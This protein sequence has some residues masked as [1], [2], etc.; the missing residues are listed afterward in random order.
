MSM[1]LPDRVARK[2]WRPYFVETGF[3]MGDG[4][5]LALLMGY[6]GIVSVELVPERAAMGR[7]RYEKEIQNGRVQIIEGRSEQVLP[8]LLPQLH[9]PTTFWLDAHDDSGG[10]QSC[11]YQEVEA[12][13]RHGIG[14]N[15]VMV[16]DMRLFGNP[17][18]W[19][20]GLSIGTLR[21]RAKELDPSIQFFYEDSKIAQDDILVM[22]GG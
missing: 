9:R 22:V 1:T 7:T 8:Q 3:C 13:L 21:G 17:S 11:V 15:V 19:G 20:R 6:E 5:Y 2:Y 14:N 10:E 12:I 18:S 4:V 16:D